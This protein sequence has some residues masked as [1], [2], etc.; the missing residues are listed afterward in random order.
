ME[1]FWDARAR[2]DAFF[3]VDSRLDYGSPDHEAFWTGGVEALDRMLLALGAEVTADQVVV[4]IGCGLGRLTRPLAERAARV[5]AVDISKE[6]L[7]KARELNSDLDNVEWMHGDGTSLQPVADASVDACVSHVVFR[8]MPD[9]AI[10]LGY[11]RDMGRVL[12]RGGFAA[13]ELST[14]PEAHRPR[15]VGVRGRVAAAVGRRPRGEADPAWV[16]SSVDVRDLR[17]V[18][19]EAGLETARIVGEATEFCAVLLTRR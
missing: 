18:A 15:T 4:D 6:M 17:E 7:A 10:T 19:A 12:R 2:E 16:G 1:Q 11:V 5:I 3:F 8:H 9:P 13:F 14:D